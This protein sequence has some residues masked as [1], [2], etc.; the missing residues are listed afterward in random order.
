MNFKIKSIFNN[1]FSRKIVL[2]FNNKSFLFSSKFNV[3]SFSS[4]NNNDASAYQNKENEIKQDKITEENNENK[5]LEATKEN[6]TYLEKLEK[7]AL[8]IYKKNFIYFL[9]KIFF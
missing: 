6:K 2:N 4:S 8:S 1:S 5:N 3:K 7:Q 9:L